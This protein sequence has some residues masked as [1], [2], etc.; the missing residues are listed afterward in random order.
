MGF[1]HFEI[2]TL[3]PPAH[4]YPGCHQHKSTTRSPIA[5]FVMAGG[6]LTQMFSSR[7]Y[8]KRT[9][10]VNSFCKSYG[11]LKMYLIIIIIIII[12]ILLLLLLLLLT[13]IRLSPG[14][15]GYL[16]Q[17]IPMKISFSETAKEFSSKGPY[18]FQDPPSLLFNGYRDQFT[19]AF[20][21]QGVKIITYLYL[22]PIINV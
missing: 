17:F 22:Q 21:G 7:I 10:N 15:S 3:P 4:C 6:C 19:S 2:F 16:A 5:F 8:K 11:V 18:R 20:S 13:A 1:I 12:I 14:G 9:R